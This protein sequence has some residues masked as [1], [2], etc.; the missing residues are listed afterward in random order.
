MAG[1]E[2]A[3]AVARRRGS[4]PGFQVAI[5]RATRERQEIKRRVALQTRHLRI[6]LR[7][8][9]NAS[10]SPIILRIFCLEDF[11]TARLPTEDLY[12][13]DDGR[14]PSGSASS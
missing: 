5:V 8:W 7:D 9:L 4:S 12:D 10:K 11:H 6:K 14:A 2:P 3:R 13:V 1:E